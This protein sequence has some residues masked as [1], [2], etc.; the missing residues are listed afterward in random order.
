MKKS[1]FTLMELIVV[2][3]IIA[4]LAGIIVPNVRKLFAGDKATQSEA[5]RSGHRASTPNTSSSSG[6]S[7]DWNTEHRNAVTALITKLEN[8]ELNDPADI[9]AEWSGYVN[10]WSDDPEAG[11]R[12]QK[13]ADSE[14]KAEFLASLKRIKDELK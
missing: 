6:K 12:V 9:K 10:R 1:G 3:A 13:F 14:V 5:V 11:H 4:I 2:V 7:Y 8:D